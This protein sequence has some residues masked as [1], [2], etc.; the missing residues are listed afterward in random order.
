MIFRLKEFDWLVECTGRMG[1]FPALEFECL[2]ECW[3]DQMSLELTGFRVCGS[4]TLLNLRL[5]IKKKTLSK[6]EKT[7]GDISCYNRSDIISQMSIY[8]VLMLSYR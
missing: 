3:L 8:F 7:F 5:L 4:R 1:D 6:R 2:V